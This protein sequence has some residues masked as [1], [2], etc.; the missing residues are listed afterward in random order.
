MGKR[1]LVLSLTA[2]ISC[3]GLAAKAAPAT[4]NTNDTYAMDKLANAQA[5]LNRLKS[6]RKA[7]DQLIQAVQKD[8][9]AAQI[10]A[11]AEKIQLQADN[12]KQNAAAVI[13]QT[14]LAIDLPNLM[15]AEGTTQANLIEK[16]AIKDDLDMMFKDKG[17]SPKSASVF[18]PGGSSG[19]KVEPLNAKKDIPDYIK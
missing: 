14:G 13:E 12:D 19:R 15:T 4:I 17:S 10:R 8:L 18:F 3:S 2:L 11:K 6:Q 7:I 5:Q 16:K 1:L 9:R